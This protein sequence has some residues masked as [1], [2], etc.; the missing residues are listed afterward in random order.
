MV[1]GQLY[2]HRRWKITDQTKRVQRERQAG[3]QNAE[4]DN[5]NEPKSDWTLIP[6][7]RPA[8]TADPSRPRRSD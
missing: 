4:I 7:K 6:L 8:A 1:T 5:R 3:R 2:R